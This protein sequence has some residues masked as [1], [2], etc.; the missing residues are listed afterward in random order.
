MN[1]VLVL[2]T[3]TGGLV[4]GGCVNSTAFY[5]DPVSKKV[6]KCGGRDAPVVALIRYKSEGECNEA[7]RAQGWVRVP[8]KDGI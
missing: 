1:K 7:Y 4:A 6:A 5:Q 2:L 8:T 3:V